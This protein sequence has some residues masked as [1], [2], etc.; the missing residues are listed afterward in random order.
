MGG[1]RAVR[2]TPPGQVEL[3][4]CSLLA[5]RT[6]HPAEGGGMRCVA[7]IPPRGRRHSDPPGC[8]A[9]A[10]SQTRQGHPTIP[11]QGR[12]HSHRA[13]ARARAHARTHTPTHIHAR[14]HTHTRARTPRC[15]AETPNRRNK[16]TLIAEPLEKVRGT[17]GAARGAREMRSCI[18]T[19][20]SRH[21]PLGVPGIPR[22]RARCG[23]L[24]S[25]ARPRTCMERE[26]LRAR[27]GT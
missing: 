27:A 20:G 5:R 8:L 1:A 7:G 6:G 16:L 22:A 2:G 25:M 15:F 17:G 14:T 23:P 3:Q 9:G 24:L 21:A 13:P 12:R 18:I 26:P 4:P 11:P 10:A 19:E